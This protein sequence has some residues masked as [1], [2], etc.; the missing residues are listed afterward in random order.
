M[1]VPY[2]GSSAWTIPVC[3][4][5]VLLQAPTTLHLH[6]GKP[7]VLGFTPSFANSKCDLKQA[8]SSPVASVASY[9][10]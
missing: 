9:T 8:I 5:W 3:A 4:Y 6:T 2:L 1:L 10:G 7:E